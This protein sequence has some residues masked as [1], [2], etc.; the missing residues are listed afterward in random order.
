MPCIIG[1]IGQTYIHLL[2]IHASQLLLDHAS[3]GISSCPWSVDG[4]KDSVL[5]CLHNRLIIRDPNMPIASDASLS[6]FNLQSTQHFAFKRA[7]KYHIPKRV[8]SVKFTFYNLLDS[9]VP[10]TLIIPKISNT[11]EYLL[12]SAN[13]PVSWRS[14][15]QTILAPRL[16]TSTTR[17]YGF[18]L[19][20]MIW[21]TYLSVSQ[22]HSTYGMET[23]KLIILSGSQVHSIYGMEIT[24]LIRCPSASSIHDSW[25][26]NGLMNVSFNQP[27]LEYF[28]KC[29]Q[30]LWSTSLKSH[31]SYLGLWGLD[32]SFAEGQQTSWPLPQ[33]T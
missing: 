25:N 21:G 29:Y 8:S 27:D 33:Q 17:Q 26:G 23:T 28:R 3:F 9:L 24:K 19:Y 18:K 5:K 4:W 30:Q 13:G 14:Q 6:I 22:V 2:Y 1:V 20:C 10:L 32:G 16:S 12:K 7:L 11:F 31:V 15:K